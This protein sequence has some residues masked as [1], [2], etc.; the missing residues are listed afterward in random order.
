MAVQ[1]LEYGIS[2]IAITGRYLAHNKLT[3]V[4]RAFLAADLHTGERSLEAPTVV[5]AALLARVNISYAH[6]ALKEAANR[7]TIEC[8]VRPLVLPLPKQ[9]P[10]VPMPMV[11]DAQI[12]NFVRHVGITRVLDAAVAVEA[13]E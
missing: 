13:A 6:H 5:Q 10:L 7:S 8:G 1:Y 2:S 4:E 3:V 11:D 9:K 12:I